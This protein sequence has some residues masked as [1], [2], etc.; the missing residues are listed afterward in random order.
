MYTQ[1]FTP[2]EL[3]RCTNQIERYNSNMSK[4]ELIKSIKVELGNSLSDGTYSFRLKES[5]GLYLNDHKRRTAGHLCQ[6]LVFETDTFKIQQYITQN[7]PQFSSETYFEN[8]SPVFVLGSTIDRKLSQVLGGNY[9][10]TAFP[11]ISRIVINHT[12]AGFNGGLALLEDLITGQV[13]GR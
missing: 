7:R 11:V 9:L 3:Y 8:L 4:E 2:I 1:S 5:N 6:E 12:Y 13:A 10:N